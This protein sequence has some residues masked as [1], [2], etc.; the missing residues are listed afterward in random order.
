[1]APK[2]TPR[3]VKRASSS[4]EDE[5]AATE[6]ETTPQPQPLSSGGSRRRISNINDDGAT[7]NTNGKRAPLQSV[8]MNDDAAEK[9]KRRQ[10]QKVTMILPEDDQPVAG[11]SSEGMNGAG[12]ADGVD[13]TAATPRRGLQRLDSVAQVDA[14]LNVPLDVMSS[15]FEEWMKMATDNV[16]AFPITFG[17]PM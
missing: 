15:N 7:P 17:L 16:G 4:S 10:S 8:N 13:G 2:R 3:R 14:P 6:R 9:R 12:P 11:P 5:G 1:M